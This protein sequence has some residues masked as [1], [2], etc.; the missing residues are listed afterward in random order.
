MAGHSKGQL[1]PSEQQG[2]CK[3][4]ESRAGPPARAHPAG[5]EQG[6]EGALQ[7]GSPEAVLGTHLRLQQQ[8]PQ[9]GTPT[10]KRKL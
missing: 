6:E 2:G 3:S 1:S 10:T 7:R 5:P 4:P 8:Q 9:P